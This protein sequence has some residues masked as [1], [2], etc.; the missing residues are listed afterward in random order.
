VLLHDR[1]RVDEEPDLAELG[2]CLVP[3][4]LAG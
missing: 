4:G 3:V 1:E 2:T